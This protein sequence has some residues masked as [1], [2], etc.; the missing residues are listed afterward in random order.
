[1]QPIEI[2]SEDIVEL[3]IEVCQK[4]GK[5]RIKPPR[6]EGMQ[7]QLTAAVVSR[8]DQKVVGTLSRVGSAVRP[9]VWRLQRRVIDKIQTLNEESELA[10]ELWRLMEAREDAYMSPKPNIAYTPV[11]FFVLS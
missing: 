6:M 5:T 2:F 8:A 1:M 3:P 7:A 9:K 11:F 10:Q 4:F